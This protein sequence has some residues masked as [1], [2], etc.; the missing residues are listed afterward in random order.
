MADGIEELKQGLRDFRNQA[1]RAMERATEE[2]AELL[3]SE[4]QQLTSLS[5]HDQRDLD[6]L[7]NPYAWREPPGSLHP[8]WE[9]HRQSGDL[10]LGL[11]TEHGGVWQNGKLD[12]EIVSD[13]DHTWYLLLGTKLMRPRDF[14]SA[15]ILNLQSE[16]VALYESEFA[17]IVDEYRPGGFAPQRKLIPHRR[18]K[19]Q[20]PA[21]G[22]EE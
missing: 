19:A 7:G 8:D 4:M 18:F 9:V 1:R 10:Q 3:L 2:A 5:D 13:S 21:G 15:A 22:G 12:S 6:A 16:I 14:V 11:R 17:K 20:L